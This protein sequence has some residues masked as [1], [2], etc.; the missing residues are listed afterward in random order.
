MMGVDIISN[1]IL[2]YSAEQH[3]DMP[4][5]EAIRIATAIPSLYPPQVYD[6]KHIIVDAV[7]VTHAPIWI[8]V[9]F[10]DHL[11]IVVIKPKTPA[12]ERLPS[13]LASY[14]VNGYTSGIIS[15]DDYTKQLPAVRMIEIDTDDVGYDEFN[16]SEQKK[17]HLIEAGRQ[18]ADRVL[19]E[20][21]DGLWSIVTPPMTLETE[22]NDYS[23][24]IDH[25]AEIITGYRRKLPQMAREQIFI[26][27]SHDDEMW[28]N[29]L[30]THLEKH[31][32]SRSILLWDDT[33]IRAGDNWRNAIRTALA[34]AKIAV[35][36][37]STHFLASPYIDQVELNHLRS[38]AEKENVKLIWF[39]LDGCNHQ[40]L[41]LGDIQAA[42]PP[43]Q[44][45]D[46][47]GDP[48]LDLALEEICALIVEAFHDQKGI[49]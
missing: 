28:L 25:A 19:G 3:P 2:V 39:T 15:R 49:D 31:P 23:S 5:S 20:W 4:V 41:R 32:T 8:P 24:A 29:R 26:S 14:V 7:F 37:V 47:L 27:Y 18:E 35:L 36:M 1:R 13:N 17:D 10:G 40:K 43:D 38:A 22:R 9:S 16:M 12:R 30:K 33:R 45:L 11:P 44:P 21:G 48:E 6:D 34:S 42:R 46:A